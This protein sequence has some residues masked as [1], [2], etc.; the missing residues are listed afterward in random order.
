MAS[1]TSTMTFLAFPREIRD[2]IYAN[3]TT[4]GKTYSI[5]S[6]NVVSIGGAPEPNLGILNTCKTLQ[7]E[8]LQI[9]CPNNAFRFSFPNADTRVQSLY[10]ELAPRTTHMEFYIDFGSF[11]WQDFKAGYR[12]PE[13]NYIGNQFCKALREW[14]SNSPKCESCRIIIDDNANFISAQLRLQIFEVMKTLVGLET[15]LILVLNFKPDLRRLGAVLGPSLGPS[16]V[17]YEWP[18]L[19]NDEWDYG[20]IKFHPRNFLAEQT[21]QNV[22]L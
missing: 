1:D 5:T 10:H 14:N 13:I 8:M 19:Y 22:A 18:P 20:S 11:H 7:H 17:H 12:D 2:F 3:L 15:V 21:E 6:T 16:T 4:K 9:L